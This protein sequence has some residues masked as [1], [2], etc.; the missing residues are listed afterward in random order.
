MA[1]MAAVALESSN[2]LVSAATRAPMRRG[3]TRP[4]HATCTT[5]GEIEASFR[6]TPSIRLRRTSQ[7]EDQLRSDDPGLRAA[8]GG[9]RG[10]PGSDET[11][12]TTRPSLFEGLSDAVAMGILTATDA[13]VLFVACAFMCR[14]TA[15]FSW[16]QVGHATQRSHG[17]ARRTFRRALHRW[18]M[19]CQRD[20]RLVKRTDLV[21]VRVVGQRTREPWRRHTLRL[22]E[23]RVVTSQRITNRDECERILNSHAV[24]ADRIYDQVRSTPMYRL[25]EALVLR[26][27][28]IPNGDSGGDQELM[29]SPE[30]RHNLTWAGRK[31]RRARARTGRPLV[32]VK[33]I[34]RVLAGKCRS[35]RECHAPILA[36]CRDKRRINRGRIFCDDACKMRWSRRNATRSEAATPRHRTEQFEACGTN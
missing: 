13:R 14:K 20:D 34:Y 27:A 11:D 9:L 21:I 4:D 15:R 12:E 26:L 6:N 28:G 29:N 19:T 16:R 5:C 24:D 18:H 7:G 32:T 22:G 36:G 17:R 3:G 2:E 23:R 8:T 35:C 1:E 10:D 31:L 33:D 25:G 30:W